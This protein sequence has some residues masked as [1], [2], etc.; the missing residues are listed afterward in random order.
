MGIALLLLLAAG[1]FTIFKP[2]T[3]A[4]N[5]TTQSKSEKSVASATVAD[6]TGSMISAKESKTNDRKRPELKNPDLVSKYGESRVNL[7]R[8]IT[9][10]M[11]EMMNDMNEM[12]GKEGM[13]KMLSGDDS[14]N[15]FESEVAAKLGTVSNGLNLTADQI[16]KTA[17]LLAEAKRRKMASNQEVLKQF[18]KDPTAMMRSLLINDAAA[19][20]EIDEPEFKRLKSEAKNLRGNQSDFST[21][22][23]NAE[24]DPL[25]DHVFVRDLKSLLNPEQQM[26]VENELKNQAANDKPEDSKADESQFMNQKH[27]EEVDI[28]TSAG[29]KMMTGAKSMIEQI[30]SLKKSINKP[31][32]GNK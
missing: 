9:S 4:V 2:G 12:G 3:Q 25:K 26:V 17:I 15:N 7:S 14:E 13:K 22:N 8:H 19:R 20:R 32:D 30:V 27:L 24:L 11:V 21:L 18:S 31:S 10:D 5:L 6:K 1:M 28:L 29:K 23:V 16:S